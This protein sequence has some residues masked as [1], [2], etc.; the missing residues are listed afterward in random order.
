MERVKEQSSPATHACAPDPSTAKLVP[1][2]RHLDVATSAPAPT[3]I[4]VPHVGT[5]PC[6]DVS[7]CRAETADVSPSAMASPKAEGPICEPRYVVALDRRANA[8]HAAARTCVR[9][10]GGVA[11]RYSEFL[12]ILFPPCSPYSTPYHTAPHQ[13]LPRSLASPANESFL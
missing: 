10:H 11:V 12:V 8:M 7:A 3:G 1:S 13:P 4:E 9:G 5:P 6:H 2:G